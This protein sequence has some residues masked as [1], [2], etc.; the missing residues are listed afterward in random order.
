MKLNK[1]IKDDA[2]I[3]DVHIIKRANDVFESMA[4]TQDVIRRLEILGERFPQSNIESNQQLCNV[5]KSLS[6][7]HSLSYLAMLDFIENCMF[8]N[9][10]QMQYFNEKYGQRQNAK[11]ANHKYITSNI[12]DNEII[13]PT[14]RRAFN[15]NIKVMNKIIKFYS[16]QYDINN[17]T[18][19][20]ARDKNTNEEAKNITKMQKKN[21]DEIDIII[22]DNDLSNY[23]MNGK[24]RLKLTL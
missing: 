17:I 19:E 21:K 3:F 24:I 5:I 13:S 18:F 20:L 8:N 22:K 10:N 16:D 14:A 9:L 4:T 23:K 11:F 6:S 2:N 7:T 12:Y 15:Q 1:I